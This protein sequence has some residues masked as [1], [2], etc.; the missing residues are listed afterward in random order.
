MIYYTYILAFGSNLGDREANCLRG[1]QYLSKFGSILRISRHLHTEPL[2]S[3]KFQVEENQ[4]YFLNYILE[5]RTTLAPLPLYEKIRIIED[6]L[7]H[8]RGSKKWASRFLDIDILELKREEKLS[9]SEGGLHIP[10]PELQNRPF[11]LELLKDFDHLN[12]S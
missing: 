8:S 11:L 7:G 5:Y 9:F 6:E 1:E 4:E 3:D 12:Y 10:H 2:K